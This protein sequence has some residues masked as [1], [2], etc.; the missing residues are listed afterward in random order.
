MVEHIQLDSPAAAAAA[1]GGKSASVSLWK[2]L[3]LWWFGWWKGVRMCVCVCVC[4]CVSRS[5][6]I[7]ARQRK[8]QR[9]IKGGGQC[10]TRGRRAGG[11]SSQSKRFGPLATARAQRRAA[12]A[13]RG[14]LKKR[15]PRRARETAGGEGA[16][17]EASGCGCGRGGRRV[18][19]QAWATNTAR[20]KRRRPASTRT[21]SAHPPRR[22]APRAFWLLLKAKGWRGAPAG[23]AMGEIGGG[24]GVQRG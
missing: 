23:A 21:Q 5:L 13:P 11:C 22:Q 1:A 10:V 4:V 7:V 14:G 16:E 3:H 8:I 17:R 9:F 12:K 6:N 15:P 19:P 2:W 20:A 24:R 18:R